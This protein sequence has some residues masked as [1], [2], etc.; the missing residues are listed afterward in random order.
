MFKWYGRGEVDFKQ[1]LQV[2]ALSTSN[3]QV[4][5]IQ[6]LFKKNEDFSLSL[7]AQFFDDLCLSFVITKK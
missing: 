3:N 6:A 7:H 5:E 4:F 2:N 1:H